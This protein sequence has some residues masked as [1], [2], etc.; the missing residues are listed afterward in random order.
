MDYVYICRNGNNEELRYSLRSI[1]K[2]MPD[3]NVW[4]L[5]YRPEWYKG[6]YIRV[7]DCS[8][9][10][11]NIKNCIR[12]IPT[13]NEISENFILMN[14]DFFACNKIDNV[15]IMH[16]GLLIDKIK[17]YKELRMSS[18]YIRLLEL[19]Y[20]DLVKNGISE[21]IDYDI[22][23]PLPMTKSGLSQ[24]IDMAYFPRSGYGNIKNIG[25][26]LVNDVKIYSKEKNIIPDIN[27]PPAMLSTEDQSF[28]KIKPF[29][30]TLFQLPSRFETSINW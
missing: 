6:N 16:G 2:N 24:T 8:T 28:L 17:K 29:L 12:I 26:V 4:V 23:V 18:K 7:E 25:G 10:F 5:G 20:K 30:D 27:H 9:K 1:E 15:E 14:D 13:I 19:T 21:P 11:E 3:G 22:H